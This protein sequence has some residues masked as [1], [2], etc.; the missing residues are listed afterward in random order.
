[1]RPLVLFGYLHIYIFFAS[2]LNLKV[3]SAD[4]GT[5][6]KKRMAKNSDVSAIIGLT[7]S[8]IDPSTFAALQVARVPTNNVISGKVIFNAAQSACEGSQFFARKCR[9]VSCS[10]L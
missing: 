10:A 4:I 2:G 1:M 3:D 7:R 6:M 5:Y 8:D 9:H